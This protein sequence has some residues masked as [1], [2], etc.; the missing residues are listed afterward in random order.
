M[1]SDLKWGLGALFIVLLLS[2]CG[3]GEQQTSPAAKRCCQPPVNVIDNH[4][5]YEV[6]VDDE[7][8]A[9]EQCEQ[10]QAHWPDTIRADQVYFFGPGRETL[11]TCEAP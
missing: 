5:Q 11:V 7:V 3:G 8:Q 9:N 2:G 1:T 6:N 4:G 10:L